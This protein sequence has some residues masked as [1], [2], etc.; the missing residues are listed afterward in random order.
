MSDGVVT[1]RTRKFM[2]NSL[3]S[4]RQM[5][6]DVIHPGAANV[7][8]KDLQ[9][10]VAKLYKVKDPAAVSLFGFKTAFGGGKSTG[11]CLIYD[12]V[13]AAKKFEPKYRQVRAGWIEAKETARKQRKERKNRAKKFRGTAKDKITGKGKKKE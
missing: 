13:A 6:L 12:D 3:L 4:R 5:I 2:T 9:E 10:K 7:S 11:F 8:K 1:L